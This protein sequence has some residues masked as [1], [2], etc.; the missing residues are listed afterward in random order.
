VNAK[1]QVASLDLII[2]AIA[3]M[4]FL[5]II[6][7]LVPFVATPHTPKTIYGGEVFTTIAAM[8]ASFL[9]SYRI[10]EDNLVAFGALDRDNV[11]TR[12]IAG[13]SSFDVSRNDVCIFFL[14][15]GSTPI[16]ISPGQQTIGYTLNGGV[17]EHCTITEPCSEDYD[18]TYVFA[19]PV[20]RL[21]EIATM[22]VVVCQQ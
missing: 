14:R 20:L 21:R 6:I 12:V 1:A 3:L 22:Y 10:N 9:T 16:E 13:T 11:E 17:A 18:I 5:A 15:G 4:A 2:S 8:P 19:Q 7:L